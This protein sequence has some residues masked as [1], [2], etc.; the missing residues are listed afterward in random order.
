MGEIYEKQI[1]VL[2]ID[3]HKVNT[4]YCDNYTLPDSSSAGETLYRVV[5][6]LEA[7]GRLTLTQPIAQRLYAAI[8]SDT[9]GFVF[10]NATESTYRIAARLVSVGIDHAEINRRLFHSK[11]EEQIRA[12]G[13]AALNLKTAKNGLITY[14]VLSKSERDAIALPFG[15]FET[16]IDVVRGLRGSEIAFVLKETDDGKFKASIRSVSENVAEIAAR[17]SGGGH[18]RAAGCTIEAE[19]IEKASEILLSELTELI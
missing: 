18:V 3:H 2:S 6:E 15:A 12:E 11:S 1:P 16:A 9:G 5:E 8:A 10:S 19:N 13:Y 4:P 14:L 7:M 17:H